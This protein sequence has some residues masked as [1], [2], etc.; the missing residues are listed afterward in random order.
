MNISPTPFRALK[1]MCA[2]VRH[3]SYLRRVPSAPVTST[4]E[5]LERFVASN[6]ATYVPQRQVQ[7]HLIGPKA[8][9]NCDDINNE[10]TKK[11]DQPDFMLNMT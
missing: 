10:Y 3:T 8:Q 4:I 11:G 9:Q 7:V 5:P 6:I 1:E 2:R